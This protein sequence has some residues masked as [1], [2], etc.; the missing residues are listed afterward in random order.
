MINR[1]CCCL[2]FITCCF[3]STTPNALSEE[4]RKVW[5]EE[6]EEG[7][8]AIEVNEPDEAV[9]QV[10]YQ[11]V[12]GGEIRNHGVGYYAFSTDAEMRK[13]QMEL[14]SSL[15]EKVRVYNHTQALRY[16]YVMCVAY[17]ILALA[18]V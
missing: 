18:C 14:L 7:V 4:V 11:N 5:E 3:R 17:S 10:H 8:D 13:E 1:C 6:E 15:R 9:R 16:M 2:C 12:Q